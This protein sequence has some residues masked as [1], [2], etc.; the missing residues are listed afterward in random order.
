MLTANAELSRP[1]GIGCSELSELPI[2]SKTEIRSLRVLNGKEKIRN[3][4]LF[5]IERA[6]LIDVSP[7]HRVSS[8]LANR[9]VLCNLPRLS[10]AE[11][12]GQC[13]SND[14]P[15]HMNQQQPQSSG[16]APLASRAAERPSSD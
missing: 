6:G 9:T 5:S 2:E 1:T 8:E 16:Q 13:R 10:G 3:K 4:I 11:S 15:Q 7:R 14:M 12:Q